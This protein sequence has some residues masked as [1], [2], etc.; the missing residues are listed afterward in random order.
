MRHSLAIPVTDPSQV[1]D[2]R[3][4]TARFTTE[5][6]L[7]EHQRGLAALVVT[8]LANNLAKYAS[9][10]QLII[11]S[12]AEE[13][14]TGL[15][16]LSLDSGP[17]IADV[18]KC[19]ADG[20]SSGGTPGNG[21]GAV[22]RQSSSFDIYS[23]PGAGTA[24]LSRIT[25]PGPHPVVPSELEFGAV[26]VP[27][28]GE[29]VCGDSWGVRQHGA[30]AVFMLVDGLGHGSIA[31]TAAD[32]AVAAFHRYH[33][34]SAIDIVTYT[35]SALRSTRGAVMAVAEVSLTD[36]AVLFAGVGNIAGCL[37]GSGRVQHMISVNGTLGLVA[38]PK[39]FQYQW[40]KGATML[41]T[42]DGLQ[43]RWQLERFPG[44][45]RKHPSLLAGMLYQ[46]YNR[47]RDDTTVIA[48]RWSDEAR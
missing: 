18:S 20:Y 47:N 2:A 45:L 21:L 44:L 17:G 30:R 37:I 4:I 5:L 31:A 43:T 28:H 48:I 24:I 11:R 12:L 6:G 16:I 40:M 7:P 14:E 25:V 15:E 42:S 33:D 46:H 13:G 26:C 1:G 3:R 23:S 32:E 9:Q 29:D 10:G 36:G 22:K 38:K 34:Q 19:L 8:E 27:I 39:P 35:H 41:L